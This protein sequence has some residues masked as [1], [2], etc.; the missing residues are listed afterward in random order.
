VPFIWKSRIRFGDTDASGRIYYPSL[1]RHFEVAEEEFLRAIG[2][3]Y[4]DL[5]SRE[6]S[7]PRVHVEADFLAALRYDDEVDIEVAPERVGNASFTLVFV[8]RK[9]GVEAARGRY[10]IATMDRR[11]QRSCP[12]P[13]HFAAL[14]REHLRTD[15]ARTA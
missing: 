6:V 11:T 7:Y 4:T 9:N 2:Q 8:V 10:V 1:F 3:P 15:D 13:E 14:L 5:E 12:V